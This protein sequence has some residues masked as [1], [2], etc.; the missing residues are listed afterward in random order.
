MNQKDTGNKTDHLTGFLSRW[1]A[2][3]PEL[4]TL[5]H[6]LYGE[7]GYAQFTEMLRLRW[8]ARP[9]D[10]LELDQQRLKHPRWYQASKMIGMMLYVNNFSGTFAGMPARL[11]YLEELGVTYLHIMPVFNMPES[12]ND[13]GYAV[14]DFTSIDSRFGTNEEFDIFTQACHARN[15]SVCLDFVLNHTSD[16]HPWAM[17]A[18]QGDEHRSLSLIDKA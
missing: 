18:K 11:D 16:E 8:S 10:L 2:L 12:L 4:N 15:I 6:S 14:S 13:G 17:Q 1:E 3:E 7:Q 9:D 5:Y